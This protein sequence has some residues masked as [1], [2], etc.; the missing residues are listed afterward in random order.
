M[1]MDANASSQT[2]AA[3]PGDEPRQIDLAALS[4]DPEQVAKIQQEAV[5]SALLSV[6]ALRQGRRRCDSLTFSEWGEFSK[7]PPPG[8]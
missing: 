3:L 6:A 7:A 2:T 8:V 5:K 4:L 1:N